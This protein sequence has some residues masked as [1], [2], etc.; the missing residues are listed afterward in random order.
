MFNAGLYVHVPFCRAKCAYCDFF[1]RLPAPGQTARLVDALLTELATGPV[2]IDP[3]MRICTIFVGGGTPTVLPSADLARLCDALGQVARRD[4]V[5]EFTVEANP[6]TLDDDKAAIL[7]RA[8]ANRVSVGVQSFHDDELRILGRSHRAD[9]IVRT[10]RIARESGFVRMN[11]DL[12]FGIPGQTESAWAESLRMAVELGPDHLAC[13]GLTYEPGTPLDEARVAR[14]LEPCDEDTEARMYDYTVD[15]LSNYGFDHYEISNFA[16]PGARCEHNLAYWRNEPYVG[17]GPAAAGYLDGERTRNVADIEEYIARITAGRSPVDEREHLD[18]RSRAGETAMLQL[19]LVEGIDRPWF[20]RHTGYDP[21]A[22]F[23]DAIR[24]HVAACRL[25]VTPTH[26]RLT[27][28]GLLIANTVMAD[29]LM[30]ARQG[31][32]TAG[33]SSG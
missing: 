22:L 14:L 13:Y 3:R 9:D 11:L 7:R 28:S 21:M 1:S 17:I 32:L 26:I 23:G 18:P 24:A 30:V 10:V 29:F 4:A 2:G 33:S 15:T 27:R 16:R 6:A 8:G 5:R 31:G 25:S 20:R 19:R 12:I